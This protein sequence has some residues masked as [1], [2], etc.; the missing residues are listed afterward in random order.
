MNMT[1]ILDKI[2][3]LEYVFCKIIKSSFILLDIQHLY[4]NSHAL[5]RFIF[6]ISTILKHYLCHFLGKS[7][8]ALGQLHN[9][10]FNTHMFPWLLDGGACMYSMTTTTQQNQ[11]H[12]SKQCEYKR[13][14]LTK[15]FSIFKLY[16]IVK[17]VSLNNISYNNV[18]KDR[19]LHNCNCSK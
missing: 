15:Y 7:F 9:N 11:T 19:V 3:F 1:K 2:S 10:T 12:D 14:K 5:F 8:V 4:G 17:H 13:S 16:Q 18:T 6:S